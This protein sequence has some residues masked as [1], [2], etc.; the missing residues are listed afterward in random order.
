M[1]DFIVMYHPDIPNSTQW[2]D[3]EAYRTT[4]YAKGWRS[5]DDP[6]VTGRFVQPGTQLD[7]AELTSSFGSLTANGFNVGAEFGT[8]ARVTLPT[9][10]QPIELLAWFILGSVTSASTFTVAFSKVA[11]VTT[12]LTMKGARQFPSVPTGGIPAGTNVQLRY[13]VPAG[14]TGTDWTISGARDSGSGSGSI[15]A[16]TIYSGGVI[17]VAR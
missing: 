9:L 17:A 1:A 13:V 7:Y 8:A 14:T 3:R 5:N 2:A 16:N 11:D 6:Y 4:W 10:D 15:L 12:T